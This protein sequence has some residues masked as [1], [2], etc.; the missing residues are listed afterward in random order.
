[1]EQAKGAFDPGKVFWRVMS[2]V[3]ANGTQAL[4]A[5]EYETV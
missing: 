3:R 4:S 1:M 2:N 5:I